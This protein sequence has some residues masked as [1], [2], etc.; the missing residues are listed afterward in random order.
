VVAVFRNLSDA[1]A[2]ASELESSGFSEDE[3]YISS[4]DQSGSS[5]SSD[6]SHE[7]GITGWF[8][9]VFGGDDESDRNYYE[10]A[11]STGNV[12][13]SVET[14]EGNVDTA[15]DILNRYSPADIQRGDGSSGTGQTSSS[16]TSQSGSA[17]R[18][19]TTTGGQSNAGIQSDTANQY[20]AASQAGSDESRA[21]PVV[22]EE[23]K[24]GKRAVLKGG[25][26]VYSRVVEQPVEETVNLHE[27]RVRVDRQPV[28]RPVTES[29]LQAGR[30][31]VIE[32]Q[33][34]AEEPVVGKEARVVEE[35]RINKEATQRSETVRDTV[36]RT[37]VDVEQLNDRDVEGGST[38]SRGS[39][40]DQDFRSHFTSNYG[41]SGDT[42]ESY[43]PAYKYGYDMAG[44]PRYQGKDFDQVEQD[45]RSDYGQ[46]YPN[47][48]WEKMK[49]SIRY[50]WNKVTG[51][52]SSATT[53]R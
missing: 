29:D 8:K 26:R 3:I 13:L 32:V 52:S 5:E 38:T 47:S 10:S 11:V 19:A 41:S 28:N 45:L 43:A 12:L 49:D 9:R 23:L 36:R 46:R 27:E 31:E 6:T 20:N 48:T 17:V 2:A 16:S 24:V 42:Y 35:V 14:H 18:G 7:G 15:A 1:Q 33:E 51:K 44:D 30:D 25:V 37:Q 50:G 21:I 4:T 22:Q 53:S 39:N 40:F 34:F